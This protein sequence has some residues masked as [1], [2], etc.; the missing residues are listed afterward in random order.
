[1][2]VTWQQTTPQ[3]PVFEALRQQLNAGA[4]APAAP[5][6]PAAHDW[7]ATPTPPMPQGDTAIAWHQIMPP[8]PLPWQQ[9]AQGAPQ[10]H[11]LL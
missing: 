3:H 9:A 1:M 4:P 11:V 10:A 2:D 5:S 6:A 8:T 7:Q